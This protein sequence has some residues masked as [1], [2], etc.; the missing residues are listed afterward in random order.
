MSEPTPS[1]G[2]PLAKRRGARRPVRGRLIADVLADLPLPTIKER[3][4]AKVNEN[5]PVPPHDPTL[6]SCHVWTGDHTSFGYGLFCRIGA[7][8]VSLWL[9]TGEQPEGSHALHRCDNP[10]CVRASHLYWGTHQQNMEDR[11]ARR[12]SH[13][14]LKVPDAEIAAIRERFSGGEDLDDLAAEFGISPTQVSRIVHGRTRRLE[15][16]PQEWRDRGFKNQR[17]RLSSADREEIRSRSA[18]GESRV[19][20]A[21]TYQ[22]GSA[23][24]SE[25]VNGRTRNRGAGSVRSRSARLPLAPEKVRLVREMWAQGGISQGQIASELGIDRSTVSRILAGLSY[26]DV[27]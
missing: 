3:F 16:V 23:Y 4:F 27:A 15:P 22:V 6:G 20:L 7:H 9:A 11:A 14:V 17:Q 2:D 21:R 12:R 24:I 8:R 19:S 5:G 26:R 13:R 1:A 18:A 25:I 10:P